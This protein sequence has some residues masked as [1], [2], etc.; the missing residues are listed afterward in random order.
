M[1]LRRLKSPTAEA[2]AATLGEDGALIVEDVLDSARLMGVQDQMA[3]LIDATHH[4]RDNF[5]GLQTRRTGGLMARSPAVR[6][7]VMDNT[8]LGAARAFLS[9]WTEKILLHLTQVISIG[10]GQPA[11][12]IHRDRLAWGG[13]LPRDIEPQFNTIWALTNFTEDNGAT[14]VVPGSHRWPD[15]QRAEADEFDR[16]T[17]TAG[18]V[19]IYSGSVLHSGGANQ[20]DE[21][22]IGI[23]LTY[24]LG[25][26]RQEENQYLS[27]PPEVAKDLD[28]ELQALLGYTSGGPALGY[29]TDPYGHPSVKQPESALKSPG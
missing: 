19:L 7:L 21:T 25:W 28:P 10:P 24:C 1:P 12:I 16:A 23:N 29:Y 4:G 26:L 3:P 5:S 9:P 11:Q 15:E 27:C 2:I 18:S 14:R 13:F 6:E 20:T 22:R 17:M 8:M